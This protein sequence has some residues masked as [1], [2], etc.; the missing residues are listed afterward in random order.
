LERLARRQTGEHDSSEWKVKG[1]KKIGKS[2][3]SRTKK[4]SEEGC[5][6]KRE[7]TGSE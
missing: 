4:V 2:K 7:V 6:V 5:R 1:Y 3:I